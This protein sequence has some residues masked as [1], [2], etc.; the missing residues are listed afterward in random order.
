MP[1]SLRWTSADLESLPVIGQRY[2]IVDGELNL[3]KHFN[4]DILNSPL[5][6]GF[7]C[8]AA[9]LFERIPATAHD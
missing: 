3:S 8:P 2:E 9:T 5:L 4:P 1:T 6:P 7:A